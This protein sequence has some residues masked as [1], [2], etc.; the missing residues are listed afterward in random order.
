MDVFFKNIEI[1][2]LYS[3]FTYSKAWFLVHVRYRWIQLNHFTDGYI[4]I[5]TD[6]N[7]FLKITE[8]KV[9]IR[10]KLKFTKT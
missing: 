4:E 10:M 8:L 6:F 3:T 7:G 1:I 5:K 2:K 9:Y